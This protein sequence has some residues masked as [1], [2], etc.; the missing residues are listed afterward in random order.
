MRRTSRLTIVPGVLA[1]VGLVAC[2]GGGGVLPSMP[3]QWDYDRGSLSER[4]RPLAGQDS[5]KNAELPPDLVPDRDDD[6][7]VT[8]GGTGGITFL[9]Q[10]IYEC[11][12]TGRLR[13]CTSSSDGVSNCV[14]GQIV[15]VRGRIELEE[16]NGVCYADEAILEPNGTFRGEDSDQVGTWTRQGTGFF[17][18]VGEAFGTC[19]PSTGPVGIIGFDGQ[20]TSGTG[21]SSSSDTSD[22]N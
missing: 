5:P 13:T 16:K 17:I 20:S 3:G 14:E 1:L 12:I 10:G 6:A 19:Y 8:G 7:K 18:R 15:T 9:C 4:E 11:S 2:D 21:S 22:G